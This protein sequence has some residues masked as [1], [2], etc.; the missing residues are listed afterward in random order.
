MKKLTILLMLIIIIMGCAKDPS[1]ET[2]ILKNPE[3]STFESEYIDGGFTRCRGGFADQAFSAS[4]Y[5]NNWFD[6][7]TSGTWTGVIVPEKWDDKSERWIV[8]T[9][10]NEAGI[11]CN[12]CYLSDGFRNF[13]VEFQ[14]SGKWRFRML[15]FIEGYCS[16]QI[17]GF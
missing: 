17:I 16:Y 8:P 10:T 1:G 14:E 7:Q 5:V 3:H 6:F 15:A 4:I 13:K 11:V 9:Y 2:E 12:H